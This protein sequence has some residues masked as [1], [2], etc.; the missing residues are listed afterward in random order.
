MKIRGGVAE[1]ESPRPQV[2]GS[3]SPKEDHD[4]T[5]EEGDFL[6]LYIGRYGGYLVRRNLLPRFRETDVLDHDLEPAKLQIYASIPPTFLA[7]FA[8]V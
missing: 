1:R 2:T 8:T 4:G 7:T 6:R 3:S 5:N